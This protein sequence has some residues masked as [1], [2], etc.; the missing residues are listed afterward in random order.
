MG[1]LSR[2]LAQ[3]VSRKKGGPEATNT[4]QP[5]S[6]GSDNKSG[7]KSS[8]NFAQ[9]RSCPNGSCSGGA[10]GGHRTG[11]TCPGCGCC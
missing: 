7:P 1:L 6:P 2:I 3:F 10:T 8:G 9:T 11:F 5:T 4:G